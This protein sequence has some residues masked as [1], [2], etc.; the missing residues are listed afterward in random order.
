MTVSAAEQRKVTTNRCELHAPDSANVY[1]LMAEAFKSRS[2]RLARYTGVYCPAFLSLAAIPALSLSKA[3]AEARM[4]HQSIVSTG[5]P[6]RGG[7]G[8]TRVSSCPDCGSRSVTCASKSADANSYWRCLDCGQM[9]CP[10]RRSRN[11]ARRW[12]G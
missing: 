1:G 5:A 8:E 11:V 6:D 12:P 10:A 4:S 3:F 2:R 7:S 9:W